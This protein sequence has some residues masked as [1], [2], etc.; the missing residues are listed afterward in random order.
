[1]VSVDLPRKLARAGPLRP[2][3][4]LWLHGAAHRRAGGAAGAGTLRH[5]GGKGIG[6][7]GDEG[8][9]WRLQREV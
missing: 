3:A 9:P 7:A 2:F 6:A 5:R 8:V 4:A 1:M